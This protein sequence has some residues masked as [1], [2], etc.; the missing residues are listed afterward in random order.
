MAGVSRKSLKEEDMNSLYGGAEIPG[1]DE[2]HPAGLWIC[3]ADPAPK[4]YPSTYP[5]PADNFNRYTFW[6]WCGKPIYVSYAYNINGSSHSEATFPSDPY[7]LSAFHID[8]TYKPHVRRLDEIQS[9]S[10][11]MVFVCGWAFRTMAYSGYWLDPETPTHYTGNNIQ[12]SLLA[13]DGH[14]EMVQTVPG[15][16]PIIPDFW[17]R[18]D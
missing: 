16:L 8:D 7:G 17:F 1:L 12:A 9:P 11:M 4:N 13:V 15:E 6:A 2:A 14:S 10:R 18:K 5:N 3:P